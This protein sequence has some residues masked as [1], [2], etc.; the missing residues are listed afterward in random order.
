MSEEAGL[1]ESE[2]EEELMAKEEIDEKEVYEACNQV[3]SFI[4]DR[5]KESILLGTSYDVL[6]AKYGILPISRNSFY[7]KR[8]L[9]LKI[10]RREE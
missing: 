8:R 7:R 4:A 6:E 9:A 1:A 5:L 2:T 10:L 3:D